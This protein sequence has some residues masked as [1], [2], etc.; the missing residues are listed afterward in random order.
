ML[1]CVFA[2]SAGITIW[3]MPDT[4][5]WYYAKG[6]EQEGDA[7][8]CQ[9]NDAGLDDPHVAETKKAIMTAIAIEL[10]ANQSIRWKDFLTMGVVDHTELKIIRRLILCF[11]IPMLGEWMGVS[12]LAYFAPVILSGTAR[13]EYIEHWTVL[14]YVQVS[15]CPRASSPCFRE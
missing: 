13:C 7:V 3:F 9:L 14:T 4:P 12:L 6:R 10:E 2:L 15:V 11:W 8:L 5:R 1:Q